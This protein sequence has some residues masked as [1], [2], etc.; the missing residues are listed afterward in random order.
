MSL[1]KSLW[2]HIIQARY[3]LEKNIAKPYKAP[4]IHCLAR[5]DLG[6]KRV[7]E[8]HGLVILGLSW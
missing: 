2:L 7:I 4:K 6:L 8:S 5:T 1:F 3:H